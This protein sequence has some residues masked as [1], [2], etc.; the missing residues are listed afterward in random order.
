MVIFPVFCLIDRASSTILKKSGD[1]RQSCLIPDVNMIA[2]S[3]STFMIMFAKCLSYIVFVVFRYVPCSPTL[4]MT[5]IIK[6]CWV[7]SKGFF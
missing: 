1:S 3:F 4:T 5:F 2:S 7:L 6:A